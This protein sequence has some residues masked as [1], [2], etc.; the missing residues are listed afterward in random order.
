ML[1]GQAEKITTIKGE[2]DVA[3]VGA[4]A[5]ALGG[6]GTAGVGASIEE[7]AAAVVVSPAPKAAGSAVGMTTGM[8][9]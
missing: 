6:G 4:V 2:L 9:S 3:A 7:G 5:V 1:S 8:P